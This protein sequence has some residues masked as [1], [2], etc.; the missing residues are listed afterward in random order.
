MNIKRRFEI[1]NRRRIADSNREEEIA[2]RKGKRDREGKEAEREKEKG[3]GAWRQVLL[4][5][6]H[7]ALR[8]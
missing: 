7:K 1:R 8:K 5:R 4:D 3:D 2:R 6:C